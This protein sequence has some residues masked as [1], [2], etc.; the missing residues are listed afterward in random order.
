VIVVKR[1]KMLNLGLGF[2]MDAW[3]KWKAELNEQK[4]KGLIHEEK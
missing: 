1:V 4:C 2:F 3:E